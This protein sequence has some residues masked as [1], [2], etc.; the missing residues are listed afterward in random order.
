MDERS[1]AFFALGLAK[2]IQSPVVL[3]CTSGTAGANYFPAV[4][5]ANLG[6][7]P[8]IILTADRPDY[9]VG[10]GANQTI[11]QH[12]LFGNHV[13]FF[14]DV[15]LPENNYDSLQEKLESAFNCSNGQELKQPPGPVHL[16]FPFEEPLFPTNDE[17]NNCPKISI[18]EKKAVK[19]KTDL[20]ILKNAQKPLIIFGPMEGNNHQWEIIQLSEKINAPIFADPLSQ[21][22]FGYQNSMVLANYDFFLKFNK[23]EPDLI[24]RFGR[25]P[26]S[27]I[28]NQLLDKWKEK[29]ILVD[30][31]EQF[32]DDCP[33]FI[34]TS[35]GEYCHFQI[36]NC[37]WQGDEKWKN[38]LLEWEKQVTNLIQKESSFSEGTIVKCCVE[39][40]E[41][42]DALFIGNSMPIRD[43]DMFTITSTKNIFVFSNRGASGI[44]GVVS[45]TLGMSENYPQKNSLL[46]IGDLSFYHDMNGLLASRFN[47]NLTIVAINNSGGGI[48]SFLPIS[49]S[50]IDHFKQFWTTD[51]NL[52][53]A[54][55]ADLYHCNYTLVKNLNDLEKSVHESFNQDG[56][57]IIEI[58]ISIRENIKAHK[59]FIDKIKNLHS[60]D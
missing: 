13:R 14:N 7:V 11:N 22:R 8:L 50:R 26:T 43:I 21:L 40:L 24:I 3:I 58:E 49:E 31:W 20:P 53:I 60:C 33:N 30:A 56:V 32:N 57:K 25:K 59:N 48:F 54:K 45:S 4:I 9:L 37:K 17:Q 18:D 2:S 23:N 19:V 27:K 12:N 29:T 34:Q 38:Q 35:I 52:S 1:S 36:E 28:L 55:I 42:D 15:G 51:T 41:D 5:E 6:R 16:N 47:A 46:I 10:T 44:D 39:S